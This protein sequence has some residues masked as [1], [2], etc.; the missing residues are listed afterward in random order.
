MNGKQQNH[1]LHKDRKRRATVAPAVSP[2]N[3]ASAK[4]VSLL[5]P[6]RRNVRSR[7]DHMTIPTAVRMATE[8]LMDRLEVHGKTADRESLEQLSKHPGAN[9]PA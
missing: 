4:S 9:L 6:V 5:R 2:F 3:F 8:Q 1:R 7:G